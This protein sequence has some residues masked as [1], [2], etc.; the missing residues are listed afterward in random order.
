[1][2]FNA[3]SLEGTVSWDSGSSMRNGIKALARWGACPEDEWGYDAR[4]YRVRAPKKCYTNALAHQALSYSRVPRDLNAMKSCLANNL[5]F[6]IGF[7]V[8][9]SFESEDVESTGIAVLPP[10]YD[11]DHVLGGHA[12]LVVGYEDENE[13]FIV[14]N[15]WG[16]EW[17]NEG[18]FYMPYKYLLNENLSDD[19]WVIALVE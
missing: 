15:S 13:W 9:A 16:K 6:G 1:M 8:Y 7:T 11:G 12:V 3:R 5:P 14:R 4:R 10:A 19:F 2:Y 18:Y 17:G